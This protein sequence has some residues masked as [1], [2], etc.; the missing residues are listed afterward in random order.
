M[1]TQ[2]DLIAVPACKPTGIHALRVDLDACIAAANVALTAIQDADIV[3][4]TDFWEHALG[5]PTRENLAWAID[6]CTHEISAWDREAS[7]CEDEDDEAGTDEA[8][9]AADQI[10]TFRKALIACKVAAN[11]VACA[12]LDEVEQLRKEAAP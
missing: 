2:L 8:W 4:N 7:R 3:D 5:E 12:E 6:G 9:G 10:R 11:A 1:S